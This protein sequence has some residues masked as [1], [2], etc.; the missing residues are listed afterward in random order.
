M[1]FVMVY[2]DIDTRTLNQVHFLN[3]GTIDK[4]GRT[5]I[6]TFSV[7]GSLNNIRIKT[8][9][10]GSFVIGSLVGVV[11]GVV[12]LV[13]TSTIRS[14]TSDLYNKH[15]GHLTNLYEL[16]TNF[17][18]LRADLFMI[19]NARTGQERDAIRTR[20]LERGE[21][22]QNVLAKIEHALTT[23]AEKSA[24]A[25]LRD[26]C[27]QLKGHVRHIIEIVG[28]KKTKEAKGLLFG[29]IDA[30]K[31][32]VQANLDRLCEINSQRAGKT[33]AEG[34]NNASTAIWIISLL[35][36]AGISSALLWG[37]FVANT[38]TRPV[39][40]IVEAIDAA[41]L[42][43]TFG[44]NRADE[45]GDMLRSLDK[46]LGTIRQ[47]MEQL[48][49]I[50]VS[51]AQASTEISASTD[52]MAA[53]AEEQ[54]T[55]ATDVSA[56]VEEMSKTIL[57]NSRNASMTAESARTAKASAAHGGAVVQ[58]TVAGMR[59]I[60]EVVK[61]S[62]EGVKTLG[63]SSDQIGEIVC[64]IEDIADQTNLLALNAAIEAARA[65]E[66]G[67]GFAV[68]ADEVRKLAERTTQATKEIADMIRRIENDTAE[69]VRSMEMGT[70]EVN[71]GITL[72]DAAGTSLKEIVDVS[73]RVTEMII[74][75]ASASEQQ[76]STSEA[77]A[78]TVV[79]ISTVT[80]AST[81]GI[82]QIVRTV[83]DLNRLTVSLQQ[84]VGNFRLAGVRTNV[85]GATA[86]TT[87]VQHSAGSKSCRRANQFSG[88]EYAGQMS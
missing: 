51:I 64:V 34:E 19:L 84:I 27:D 26:G 42:S 63:R 21:E 75:I 67:R 35:L 44:S 76:A 85:I 12:G 28:Q 15:M 39:R 81:A 4:P 6:K 77:I 37:I 1:F 16:S 36:G 53:G 11:I 9:L 60:A 68:V 24:F 62:A 58:E 59:R 87:P 23:E 73:E 8:K 22:L 17:Q 20:A 10:V 29:D 83:D 82:Q 45:I 66:Q 2:G 46:F 78:K 55:Q 41:D 52:A 31:N 61:R 47:T 5:M 40:Q 49:E 65:G 57:E 38:V 14:A 18:Y 86:G 50:S 33:V 3:P 71:H 48:V 25:G 30:A 54:S 13:Q 79:Q 70:K 69:A 80:Q 74:H 88:V 32:R 43:S 7:L 56:S 72:A